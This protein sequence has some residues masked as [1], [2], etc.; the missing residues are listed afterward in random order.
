MLDGTYETRDFDREPEAHREMVLLSG[1]LAVAYLE[2][3][4]IE[5]E[6]RS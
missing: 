5:R 6:R 2:G 1:R 4:G 3:S